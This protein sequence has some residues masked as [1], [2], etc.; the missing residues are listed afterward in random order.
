M[1]S[2]QA[3]AQ[4]HTPRGKCPTNDYSEQSLALLIPG[5]R[6]KATNSPSA[7]P[8]C[9]GQPLKKFR[10]SNETAKIY[11]REKFSRELFLTRKFPDLR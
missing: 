3:C 4:V 9:N 7:R 10:R 5:S 1:I 6:L 8:Y 11:Q 2:E